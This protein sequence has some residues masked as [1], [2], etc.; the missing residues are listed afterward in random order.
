MELSKSINLDFKHVSVRDSF[1]STKSTGAQN[2]SGNA[3]A[4][5]QVGVAF[6]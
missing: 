1:S 4:R 2:V 5:I 6:P 3:R